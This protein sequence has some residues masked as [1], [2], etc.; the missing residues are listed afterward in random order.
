MRRILLVTILAAAC[1]T[2]RTV[3]E[4]HIDTRVHP[5][6]AEFRPV[7]IAVLPV[8]APDS[9]LRNGVRKEVYR[10]LPDRKYAPFRLDEV[11]ARI[12]SKGEF[13]GGSLDWDAT[14]KIDISNWRAVPGTRY[15][16]GTG[17]A[18]LRH[19]TGEI[20][21]TCAFYDYA[22]PVESRPEGIDEEEVAKRISEIFVG[23]DVANSRLPE[24]PPPPRE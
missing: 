16:A 17:K 7:T 12:N 20:L 10:T 1:Q 8:E 2:T 13:E 5:E 6:Y 14:L 18:E 24:C 23:T 11:D 19:K 22:F 9:V 3:P 21:W 15:Y 4:G